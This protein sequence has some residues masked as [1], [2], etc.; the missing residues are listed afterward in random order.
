MEIS[1]ISII[2][3]REE[4]LC[5]RQPFLPSSN[6]DTPHFLH[7]GMDK[8]LDIQFRLL[9][10]DMLNP[11]RSGLANFLTALTQDYSSSPDYKLSKELNKVQ[12]SGGRFSINNGVDNGDLQV[13]TNVQFVDVTCD[14]KKGF[15]CTMRFTPPRIRDAEKQKRENLFYIM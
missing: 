3:T 12:R 9:R 15:A 14:R 7:D 8:L 13:Y 1:E 5:D 11:I 6:P 2:P 4:I 10:E